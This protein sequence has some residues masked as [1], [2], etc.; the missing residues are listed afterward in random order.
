M[1]CSLLRLHSVQQSF[2]LPVPPA[3]PSSLSSKQPSADIFDDRIVP[4]ND[5]AL[6]CSTSRNTAYGPNTSLS[7]IT[8]F[9][10]LCA[11]A[12][13]ELYLGGDAERRPVPGSCVTS[14]REYLGM[15]NSTV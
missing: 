5:V 6:Q 10:G 4:L 7:I 14:A 11:S 9:A 2:V 3:C 1:C 8:T 13:I 15:N 12:L